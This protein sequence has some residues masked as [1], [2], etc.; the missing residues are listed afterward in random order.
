MTTTTRTHHPASPT[1]RDS[2]GRLLLA[3]WTKLR[4]VRRWVLGLLA[5]AVLTIVISLLAAAG[6]GTDANQEPN[7]VVGPDGQP[8]VDD[9]HFVHRSLS[10]DGSV[11]A[12]V[13]TQENSHQWAGAG[14]MLKQS[15]V[16]GSPYAAIMV[17]PRHGVRLRSNFTTDLPGGADTVPR[18]LRLTRSGTSVTGYESAD[19]VAWRKVGTVDLHGLPQSVEIG[20]FVSSPPDVVIERQAGSTSVGGRPTSGT[21]TFDNVRVEAAQPQQSASWANENVGRSPARGEATEMGGTFTV[22]GSGEIAPNPPPD[23]V[24]QISLFGA[25]VGLMAIVAVGVLFITSEYKRAMIRTTFAA[26]PRRGRVLAAKAIVIGVA[27]FAVGMVASVTAFVLAQPIL[28]ENGFAPPAFPRPSLSEGPVLR[29]VVGTAA[30][31]AVVAVFSLGVGALLRRS[32]GAI[33]AVIALLVL[34]V[35]IASVLPLPAARWLMRVTPAGGFAIQRA[36]EPTEALVEP[37]SLIGP[38]TGFG[39]LCAYAAVSLAVAFWL[40]RGRDA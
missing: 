11:T 32:A 21:A 4:S 34:P 2:F 1:G 40:L 5:A 26:S 3:E 39:V 10:G 15:T 22:T 27:T 14:V 18:W 33:S 38:W 24:V 7:F 12:R 16:S 29:A 35:I 30:F 8:V 13:L 19:G 23:D 25:F 37:W 20:L 31:L 28:R 36:K 9:F 6:S 17:T